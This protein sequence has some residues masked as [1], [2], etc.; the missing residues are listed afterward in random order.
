MRMSCNLRIA[1][2]GGILFDANGVTSVFVASG[3]VL[4]LAALTIV[5]AV[6]TRPA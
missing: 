2:A 5:S 4:L 1:A 6:R 3:A